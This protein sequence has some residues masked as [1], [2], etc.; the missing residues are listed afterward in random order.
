MCVRGVEMVGK[1]GKGR[2]GEG[3]EGGGEFIR[4]PK[5]SH[6]PHAWS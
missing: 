5:P 3:G 4:G 2:E 1:G 6:W